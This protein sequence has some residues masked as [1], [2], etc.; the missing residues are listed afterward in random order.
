[1]D[2][3]EVLENARR[4]LTPKCRVCPVCDGRACRGEVPGP[5][6]KGSGS[7]FVRNADKLAQVALVLDTLYEDRGQDTSCEIFGKKFAMPVFAAPVGG[8]KLNYGSDIGEGEMAARF[9]EGAKNAGTAAFT[10]D[11]P[12]TPF[13]NALDAIKKCGGIGIPTIKPWAMPQALSYIAEAVAAGAMAVSMDVDAAGLVN[14]KLR[15]KSV[16][17]KSVADLHRLAAAAGKTPFIVKGV[18]SVKGALKALEAGCAGIVVS[19]H[20]GRVLDCGQ[21][22][23][24]VLPA[25]AEAVK[26]HMT[27]FADGGVRSGLDVFKMLALGADAV[28]IGR[29]VAVAAFGGGAE[30]VEL[31]FKKIQSELAGAMLM[32]GTAKLSEIKRGTIH[33]PADF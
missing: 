30:G 14:V 27:I 7:T 6:G 28:L 20:G 17:P 19:N 15:G 3:N 11:A 21:S 33:I 10:G 5:G 23:A 31:Y 2:Y 24:E 8:M 29:P 1:M 4:V 22:T 32:T 13:C 18:M 16:Y 26:G 25:I 12:D 9:L